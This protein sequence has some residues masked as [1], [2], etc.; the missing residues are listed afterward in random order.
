[1]FRFRLLGNR[2]QKIDRQAVS[3]E[4][5]LKKTLE[6]RTKCLDSSQAKGGRHGARK[7]HPDFPGSQPASQP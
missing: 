5:A 4:T 3:P 1:M 2:I 7:S 6:K